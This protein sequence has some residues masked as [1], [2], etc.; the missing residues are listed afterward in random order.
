MP[1]SI[2]TYLTDSEV[3]LG[4]EAMDHQG[5]NGYCI[6][7]YLFPPNS[8]QSLSWL[9]FIY[10]KKVYSILEALLLLIQHT[11]HVAARPLSRFEKIDSEV[12]V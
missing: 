1:Y 6:F 10:Y 5:L 4:I 2:Y 7:I 11:L 8:G 3:I 12:F 9:I